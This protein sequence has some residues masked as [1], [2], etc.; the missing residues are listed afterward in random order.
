MKNKF[1]ILLTL[2]LLTLISCN[3]NSNLVKIFISSNSEVNIT[4]MK[5]QFASDSFSLEVSYST[6]SN[7]YYPFQ[8]NAARE[9]YYDIF[10][11]R[12]SEFLPSK[13]EEIYVPFTDDVLAL[14]HSDSYTFHEINNI[15]YGIKLNDRN[16][17]INTY[18]SFEEGHDYYLGVAKKSKNCGSYSYFSEI[19]SMLSYTVLDSLL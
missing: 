10:I 13:I 17:K 15:K 9:K 16:Y 1:L 14:F 11:L 19:T 4:Q 7:F 8:Y 12:D 2:P 5:Q 18:I 6:P 3:D